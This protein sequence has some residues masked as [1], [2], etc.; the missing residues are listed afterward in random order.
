MDELLLGLIHKAESWECPRALLGG[1]SGN[2]IMRSGRYQLRVQH[3]LRLGAG[4]LPRNGG[5]DQGV[6]A[7]TS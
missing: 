4:E 1:G 3:R 7:G 5:R 6:S 2:L